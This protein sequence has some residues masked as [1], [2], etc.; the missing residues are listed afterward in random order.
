MNNRRDAMMRKYKFFVDFE[1]EEKWLMG[2]AKQ[3]LLIDNRSFGYQF[4]AIEP[5]ETI[6]K[7]DFRKF[8]NQ[9]DFIDYCTLF[10]DSGWKHI[11]GNKKSGY[12]YFKSIDGTRTNDIFSDKIS[13]AGKYNRLSKMFMDIAISN[14]PIFI[15]F[16]LADIIDIHAMFN[17]KL[18][19]FTPGIWEMTGT[20]FWTAFLFETPIAIMR[21]FAWSIIPITIILYFIYGIKAKRLYELNKR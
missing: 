20:S 6:I 3:G 9:E 4:R 8:K 1:K 5:E 7:M 11:V 10:E 13:K 14:I 16:I 21:G 19:Y 15:V 12:Q 17:P 18:L 2:M